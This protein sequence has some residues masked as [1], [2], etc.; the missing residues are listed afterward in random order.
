MTLFISNL[1]IPFPVPYLCIF[2]LFGEVVK[3][4]GNAPNCKF[5]ERRALSLS[6]LCCTVC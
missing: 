2:Y 5:P 6:P 1:G 4:S 3:N